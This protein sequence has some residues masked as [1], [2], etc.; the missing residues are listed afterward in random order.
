[1]LPRFDNVAPSVRRI[2]AG[3]SAA[4]LAFVA[5][6][7][8]ALASPVGAS[9]DD[10]YHLV[11]IWCGAGEREGLC[12]TPAGAEPGG[13]TR[14]V[15]DDLFRESICY[16]FKPA[17]SAS[18]QD[19][20][21]GGRMTETDRGNF[22]GDYPPVFYGV[23]SIFAGENIQVSVLIMRFANAA[24][25]VG[26]LSVLTW[27]TPAARRS[28][29]VLPVVVTVVP[30]GMFIISSINASSWALLSAATLWVSLN[31]YFEASG[32]RRWVF[33]AL[34]GLALVIG[35][36]AR[37][38][39]AAY[40]G[41]AIVGVLILQARR[42]RDFALSAILPIVLIAVAIAF[43]RLSGQSGAAV[44]GLDADDEYARPAWE[45][46]QALIAV[47]DLWVGALGKWGL[48]WLDTYMPALVWVSSFAVFAGV[49]FFGLSRPGVR[50]YIA[51]GLMFA[52]LWGVP[53]L[54]QWQSHAAVGAYIQPRYI[55]PLAI[56]LV[57]FALVK[58]REP[59]TEL[60][61]AQIV[62]VVLAL[63]AANSLALHTNIRRY[64]TGSEV[65]G[66]NLSA[67]AEWWW[68]TGP[69]PM[70]TWM[71]GSIAFALCLTLLGVLIERVRT[72]G[73]EELQAPSR[74]RE[75][76]RDPEAVALV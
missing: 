53:A 31:N 4:L 29:L 49:I 22:E 1:M 47:P 10:D 73:P 16:A 60:S 26:L 38:D 33:A 76:T 24:L 42:S 48:G 71:I 37:A 5:L 40:A 70:V 20:L 56:L 11:S 19:G 25:F 9:P 17:V 34:A 50:K 32:R 3:S 7:A 44:E 28:A 2:I 39:S 74:E 64:V 46:F 51:T 65:G 30:L 61:V 57:G 18:C 35:A 41:L 63:S 58:T 45:L 72:R 69:T 13:D 14:V 59:G 6:A 75:P 68:N 8:W 67:N 55:L 12:E 52:A 21:E 43:Y 23:M 66:G 62:G 27:L 54:L 36:G 15:P